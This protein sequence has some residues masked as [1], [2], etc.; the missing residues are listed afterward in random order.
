LLIPLPRLNQRGRHRREQHQGTDVAT[1]VA[2]PRQ[3]T[4]A[5]PFPSK[6][7]APPGAPSSH[8]SSHVVVP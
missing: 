2:R 5:T 7:V 8:P 3:S 4:R 1:T 6:S